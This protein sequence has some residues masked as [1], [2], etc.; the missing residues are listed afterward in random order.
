[1]LSHYCL[2]LHFPDDICLSAICTQRVSTDRD[3]LKCNRNTWIDT[4]EKLCLQSQHFALLM[5]LSL[6]GFESRW[7]FCQ[8]KDSN[9]L[10]HQARE[11]LQHLH[12]VRAAPWFEEAMTASWC[13]GQGQTNS[14]TESPNTT[15]TFIR[16][17][18][19][20]WTS[21]NTQVYE[22]QK[23]IHYYCEEQFA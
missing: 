15:T 19:K 22:T 6:M 1:M 9:K 11:G 8:E 21:Q 16:L 23:N 18:L 12:G 5:T 2:N 3:S 20:S 10:R 17:Y 4:K 13:C 14:P 7:T